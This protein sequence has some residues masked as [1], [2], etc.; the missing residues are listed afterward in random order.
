MAVA[1]ADQNRSAVSRIDV[2]HG[3]ELWVAIAPEHAGEA[4]AGGA[5]AEK[6]IEFAGFTLVAGAAVGPMTGAYSAAD[7]AHEQCGR[8]SFARNVADHKGQPIVGPEC[9][10]EVAANLLRRV[11]FDGELHAVGDDRDDRQQVRLHLASNFD[12]LLKVLAER[13]GAET[14]GRQDHGEQKRKSRS[15]VDREIATNGPKTGGI[16]GT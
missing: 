1:E 8:N 12:L 11:V 5:L 6:T 15:D 4:I 7:Y 3:L 16:G 10:V 13:V 14:F 9:V 2:V